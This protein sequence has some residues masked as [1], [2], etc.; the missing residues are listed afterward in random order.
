[1]RFSLFER[2]PATGRVLGNAAQ[3]TSRS[4]ASGPE[5]PESTNSSSS[6][7]QV[8]D[9]NHQPNNQEHVDQGSADMQTETQKPQNQENSN[10]CPKHGNLL[11][12]QG[13]PS[14]ND[15]R[16]GNPILRVLFLTVFL[17]FL[18]SFFYDYGLNLCRVNFR[19]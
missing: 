2:L 13:L 6:A 11:F 15:R 10:N 7:H 16:N 19:K 4:T 17:S 9:Q 5:P 14:L 1:M 8:N 3:A 18:V 12:T